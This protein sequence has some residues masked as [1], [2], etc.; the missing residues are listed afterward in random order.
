MHSVTSKTHFGVCITFMLTWKRPWEL[1]SVAVPSTIFS[2]AV[3]TNRDLPVTWRYW[4]WRYQ[5]NSWWLVQPSIRCC[6]KEWNNWHLTWKCCASAWDWA[7]VTVW[8]CLYFVLNRDMF[9]FLHDD[10]LLSLDFF[11][12]EGYVNILLVEIEMSGRSA[13]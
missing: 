3:V 8:H 7:R 1:F 6:E 11:F 12:L 13:G 2:S 9:M 10:T 5:W 4:T